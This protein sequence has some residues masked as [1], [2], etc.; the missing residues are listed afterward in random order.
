MLEPDQQFLLK[1]LAFNQQAEDSTPLI[2]T[3]I[4]SW[5]YY[6]NIFSHDYVHESQADVVEAVYFEYAG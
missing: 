3:Q 4:G 2:L 5:H 6:A 1:A